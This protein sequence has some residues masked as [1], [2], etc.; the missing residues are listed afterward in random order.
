M[1][2]DDVEQLK[3]EIE[4]K[5]LDNNKDLTSTHYWRKSLEI[6]ELA[7][8][9]GSIIGTPEEM[10]QIERNIAMGRLKAQWEIEDEQA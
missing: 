10:K 6:W 9:I 5:R 7:H 1:M 2:I 4:S 3:L 8:K